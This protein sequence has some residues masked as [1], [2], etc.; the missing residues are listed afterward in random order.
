MLSLNMVIIASMIGAGGLGF[1]VLNALKRLKIG[2]GVEAGLAITLLAIAMDRLSQAMARRPPPVH[3]EEK[4]GLLSSHPY[5][6]AGLMIV[7]LTWIAGIGLDSLKSYPQSWQITTGAFWGDLVRWI[8]VNYFEQLDGIKNFLKEETMI[9]P[10]DTAGSLSERLSELGAA[11]LVPT[12]EGLG[13]GSL[14][15][16]PQEGKP[17]YAPVMKK[18][19]GLIR[20]SLSAE[21]VCNFIRHK[22]IPRARRE[23]LEVAEKRMAVPFKRYKK[24]LSHK[25]GVGPGR[26]PIKTA[27]WIA[28]LLNFLRSLIREEISRSLKAKSTSPFL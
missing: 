21:E 7:A 20:W 5:L 4:K 18:S 10:D 27:V 6:V 3:G 23:L 19:D 12:L 17:S 28:R 22:P 15:P 25:T 13:K 24:D 26:Y 11:L 14:K 2:E 8:N 16:M 9:T 1:D